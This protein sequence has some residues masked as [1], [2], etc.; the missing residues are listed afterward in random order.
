MFQ[1]SYT[2]VIPN[3]LNL[4]SSLAYSDGN[5]VF[6][7][8]DELTTEQLSVLDAFMFGKGYTRQ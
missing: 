1:Y 2:F 8:D 3:E 6:T 7:C 5:F 4:P